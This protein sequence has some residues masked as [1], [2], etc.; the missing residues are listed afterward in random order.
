MEWNGMGRIKESEKWNG[1][2]W[3]GLC[4]RCNV[5]RNRPL[6][7][8]VSREVAETGRHLFLCSYNSVGPSLEDLT[9]ILDLFEFLADFRPVCQYL[10]RLSACQVYDFVKFFCSRILRLTFN[11]YIR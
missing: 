6:G 3:N 10:R 5:E 2:E 11:G 1:M 9:E 8:L 7:T 4:D